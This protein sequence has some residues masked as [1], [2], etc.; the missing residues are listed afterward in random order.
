MRGTAR[1]Y[2][3]I[4][5]AAIGLLASGCSSGNAAHAGP[6]QR[7]GFGVGP[8]A[9]RPGGGGAED[10]S[11][12]REPRCRSL[13]PHH[14]HRDPG[15]QG[16]R[17]HGQD[18]GRPG[19]RHAAR[20]RQVLAEHLDAERGAELHG[21]RHRHRQQRPAGHHHEH[22]PHPDPR[23]DV[24][25]RDLRGLGPDL[26]RR[27]AGHADLQPADHQPGRGRALAAVHHLQAGDR[28]LVLG[29][30]RAPGASGRGTT[31][32]PTPRSAFTAA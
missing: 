25:H 13:V 28:L 18:L 20:Q 9:R 22:L 10:R 32:R 5:A 4:A 23:A 19:L 11:G 16:D 27:H 1:I 12:E 15:Q 21:D 24:Q 30:Q 29:R 26:R 31:G 14:R 3:G 8:G 2:V 6:G 17:R 7:V